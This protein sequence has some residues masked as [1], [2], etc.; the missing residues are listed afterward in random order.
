MFACV[1]HEDASHQLIGQA[2]V[3]WQNRAHFF[4]LAVQQ[5]SATGL[6]PIC[7]VHRGHIP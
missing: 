7:R 5:G 2:R 3:S 6:V 4:G 1:I